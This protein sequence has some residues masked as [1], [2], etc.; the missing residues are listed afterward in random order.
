MQAP[1]TFQR[2]MLAIFADL[3]HECVEVYM[4]EFLVY[5]NEFDESLQNLEKVL[6]RCIESNLSLSN[7]N[8]FMLLTE[9]IVLGH[10]ISLEGIKVDLEKIEI[11]LKLP[12]PKYQKYVRSF[13]GYA[14]YCRRFIQN[15]SRI[16]LPLFKLLVKDVEFFWNFNCQIDFQILKEKL[17]KTPVLRGPDWKLPFHISTDASDTTVGGVLGQKEET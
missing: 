1:A 15:F 4:D 11:I 14:G 2:A 6:K 12:S 5:G 9:G 10:H 7:E 17:S 13:L 16:A 8:C 3:I